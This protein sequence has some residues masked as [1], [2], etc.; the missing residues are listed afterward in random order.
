MIWGLPTVVKLLGMGKWPGVNKRNKKRA[1][2]N[3]VFYGLK[4]IEGFFVR[5][6]A[7]RARE[8]ALCGPD[9]STPVGLN[10]YLFSSIISF[11][12]VNSIHHM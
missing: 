8:P 10:N 1:I 3:Y 7:N 9:L 11:V 4:F 2:I 12:F 5:R 6:G